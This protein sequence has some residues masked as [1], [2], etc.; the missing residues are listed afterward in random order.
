MR[1]RGPRQTVRGDSDVLDEQSPQM[2][3]GDGEGGSQIGFRLP[4][5]RAVDDQLDAAADKLD[6]TGVGRLGG[7]VGTAAKARAEARRFGRG[8]RQKRP[9]LWPLGWA[10]QLGRQ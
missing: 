2:P 1:T 4:V 9:N 8:G 5:K 7:T 6:T 3:G 10:P